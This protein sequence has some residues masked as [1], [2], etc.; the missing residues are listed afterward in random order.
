MTSPSP[1]L[2]ASADTSTL[3]R[4]HREPQ[5]SPQTGR[6][7]S[8]RAGRLPLAALGVGWIPLLL[9]PA[10]LEIDQPGLRVAL[11]EPSLRPARHGSP[12][13]MA[14]GLRSTPVRRDA[15][16]VEVTAWSVG[17]LGPRRPTGVEQ[18]SGNGLG[19][20]A[21]LS[22]VVLK[23]FDA[24]REGGDGEAHPLGVGAPHCEPRRQG[25]RARRA[26]RWVQLDV[27][28]LGRD[29]RSRRNL[30]VR[31]SQ[32]AIRTSTTAPGSG[33]VDRSRRARA[34]PSS[35]P[36]PRARRRGR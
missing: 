7:R 21:V 27:E 19:L 23:R 25:G 13:Q 10:R 16:R 32:L 18:R 34:P 1:G 36:A 9:E 33:H 11:P 29:Q 15:G 4:E 20:P 17:L 24:K 3:D 35:E 6:G 8:A 26:G 2:P 30:V 31:L 5:R 12:G 22:V 28:A 14:P